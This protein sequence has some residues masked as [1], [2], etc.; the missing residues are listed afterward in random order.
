MAVDQKIRIVNRLT[1]QEIKNFQLEE[2]QE[3]QK[4][5][6]EMDVSDDEE[7]AKKKAREMS[8]EERNNLK[9]ENDSLK[10]QVEA[11]KNEVSL[12]DS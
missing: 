2:L 4:D 10:C 11:Y 6:D 8:N 7:P 5:D 3:K 9:D 1:L 12:L